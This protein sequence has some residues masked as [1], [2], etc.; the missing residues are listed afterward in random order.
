MRLWTSFRAWLVYR[1]NMR[2]MRVVT[3]NPP[4]MLIVA[5]STAAA[6]SNVTGEEIGPEICSIPPTRMMPL[7]A[8][9]TLISGV[10]RAGVTFHTTCQPTKQAKTNTVRC[11]TNSFGA[12]VPSKPSSTAASNARAALRQGWLT[13]ALGGSG[14][15][16][17]MLFGFAAAG[18]FKGADLGGGQT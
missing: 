3:Q 16:A 18:R 12:T 11:D 8:L 15:C 2:S 1:W 4:L 6:L 10:C 9:V 14:I 5:S 7:M 13:G 17:C